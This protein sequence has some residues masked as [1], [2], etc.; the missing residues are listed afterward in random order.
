MNWITIVWSMNAAACLTLAGIFFVAWCKQ[1]DSWGHLIFSCIALAAAGIAV[2]E[3]QLIHADTPEEYGAI[4]RW[5]YVPVWA[6]VVSLVG[7]T[8]LYLRAGRSRLAWS[9]CGLKTLT[10]ILIFISMPNVHSRARTSSGHL[11]VG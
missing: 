7:F 2:F 10:L 5:R 1:R 9:A 3:L 4:L 11:S 6:L 8:R